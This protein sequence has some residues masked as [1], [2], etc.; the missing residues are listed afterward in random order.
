ME[1]EKKILFID[2][3]LIFGMVLK[4]RLNKSNDNN[5]NI[6]LCQSFETAIHK[7]KEDNF[8]LII[9]DYMLMP[10]EHLPKTFESGLEF[11]KYLRNGN[12]DIPFALCTELSIETDN[13][14]ELKND[15]NFYYFKKSEKC[16]D[17]LIQLFEK[18]LMK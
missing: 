8:D 9:C 3:I 4:Y 16:I 13:Y 6:S 7:L 1:S 2:D 12:N 18:R 15:M 17:N 14:P 11:Y 10:S 5:F